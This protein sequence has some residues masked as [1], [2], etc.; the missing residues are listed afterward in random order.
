LFFSFYSH[1]F[2]SFEV[3]LFLLNREAAAQLR[4]LSFRR[5]LPNKRSPADGKN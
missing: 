5:F 3:L 4:V 2:D 1:H